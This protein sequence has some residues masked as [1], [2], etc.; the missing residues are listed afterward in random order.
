L[1]QLQRRQPQRKLGWM[2][3]RFHMRYATTADSA[4]IAWH[5]ARMFQDMGYVPENLFE[6]F[7]A[8]SEAR[9]REAL[10]SQEYI[11]WLASRPEEQEKIIAGAGLQLRQTLPH[12]IGRPAGDIRIIDGR[13]GIVLNVFTE[14]EWRRRGI[15][16]L[17]MEKVIAWAREQRLDTLVLHASDDA[18]RLYER[19]GFIATTEMRFDG[20]L[21]G[22]R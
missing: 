22:P 15:A 1:V 20:D 17:L 3:Q 13:Q 12:P 9:L 11:G 19:L 8:K 16:A 2:A 4:V 6:S 7:R 21:K 5:R 14:P 18:R 10:A